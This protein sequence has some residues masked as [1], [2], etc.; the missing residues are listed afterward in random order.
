MKVIKIN[1][2]QVKCIINKEDII[3]RNTNLIEL[4]HNKEKMHSLFADMMKEVQKVHGEDYQVDGIL[5]EAMVTFDGSIVVTLTKQ[6]QAVETKEV[7]DDIVD[8]DFIVFSFDTLPA[9][10]QVSSYLKN[11][12]GKN[13]LY[14]NSL[15]DKYYLVFTNEYEEGET[16]KSTYF[17]N[18]YGK[19]EN[20]TSVSLSHI[21]EHSKVIIDENAVQTLGNIV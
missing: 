13:S 16:H 11:Y 17:L 12:N 4:F 15:Q 1:E 2:N 7:N 6:N 14:K 21:M 8:N 20:L 19:K 10:M 18:D 3:S 5:M 9:I